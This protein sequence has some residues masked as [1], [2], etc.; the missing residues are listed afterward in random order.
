[1]GK[2]VGQ[3]VRESYAAMVAERAKKEAPTM[4]NAWLLESIIRA[5]RLRVRRN[6]TANPGQ[7]YYDAQI[8][9]A[10]L[11]SAVTKRL[12]ARKRKAK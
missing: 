7:E 11:E 12:R 2:T 8:Q 5:R 3:R 1:M 4:S 10:H 9:R 6:K